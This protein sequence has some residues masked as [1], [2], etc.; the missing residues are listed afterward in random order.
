M[1]IVIFC[2]GRGTRLWPMSRVSF[3]KPFVP[4]LRGKSFFQI[5]YSRYRKVYGP[6]EIFVTTEEPYVSYVR[7][8]APEIPRK[9]IIVEPERKDLLA[10]C[11]LATA[12]VNKYYP[13]EA[14]LISWAKHI[15]ER[16]SVFLNAVAVAGEYAERTGLIV[17]VDAEPG[18]ATIH[19]GWV[20]KGKVLEKMDGFKILEL[21]KHIEK[22]KQSIA[23]KLYES[24]E[25]LVNT[26]YRV[27]ETDLMLGYYK[28]YQPEIHKGLMKIV[29]A[30]GTKQQD[31]IL[32]EEYAKFVKDSIE[33][34]IFEKMPGNIR[35]TIPADMGWEDIGMSWEWY[36]KS[37]IT[38]K[39]KTVVE[40]E[41]DTQFIDSKR[42]LVI[43]PKGKMIS[44]IGVSDI[45]VVDTPDGLLVC[46]LSE[47]Q[48]VKDLYKKLE[49]YHKEYIK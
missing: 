49:R 18:Y 7:K 27:W 40:G 45:A 3:P 35:A 8:Q 33:Y 23:N 10:A 15:M 30:W 48:K 38:P 25:W 21:E 26:G 24:G 34:G 5:T 4:L 6:E 43:G 31:R 32:R 42:N 11:G 12:V 19:N 14:I 39:E 16:E 17:S 41:A 28:K 2:G 36:Y 9:N 37:L 44:L 46:K 22:P 13:G 1:K 47:T 20:K 29:G